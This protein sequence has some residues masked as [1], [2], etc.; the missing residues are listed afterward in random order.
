MSLNE[1][2]FYLLFDA[3]NRP[4]KT[5]WANVGENTTLLMD[6]ELYFTLENINLM[7]VMLGKCT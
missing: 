2:P 6:L 4:F 3:K 7:S 1:Y 5:G